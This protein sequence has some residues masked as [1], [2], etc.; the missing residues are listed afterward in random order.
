MA[1]VSA[2]LLFER[3]RQKREAKEQ[4]LS[5]RKHWREIARP[6]QI[7]PEGRWR[8]WVRM[9]GRGEGKTRSGAETTLEKVR[10]GYK[11]ICILA[12]T[13]ADGRDVCVE[14]ESG[15]L[16][17]ALPGEIKAWNRSM[18][19]IYFSTGAKAKIFAAV[20]PER[21]R[22]PQHDWIWADEA[23]TPQYTENVLDMALF[24]LR[25]GQE[26]Q[27][28]VT[29]TPRNT[30]VIRRLKAMEG[31]VITAGRTRDN[32]QNLAPGIVDELERRYAG[33]R[34]GQQELDGILLEDV[35]GAL[36]TS[37]LIDPHRALKLPSNIVSI[38]VGV[39]PSV[40]DPERKKNPNKE[41]DACGIVVCAVS[42]DHQGWVINDLSGVMHPAQ[43][44]KVAAGAYNHYR[45]GVIAAEGNQGGELVKMA[46][47]AVSPNIN[48]Q[49][50]HAS[51]G[52]RARAEPL[53]AL[54]E[55]GRIHHVAQDKQGDPDWAHLRDL[56]DE[57]LTW[58]PLISESPNRV[59]AL[60]WCFD[61]LGLIS[62][63]GFRETRRITQAHAHKQDHARAAH[64]KPWFSQEDEEDE[65]E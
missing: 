17:C 8:I 20:E 52:K 39:D 19:E 9:C 57:M 60:V 64:A 25:L 24:G 37:D 34:I 12:P 16:A 26:P 15:I 61:A 10:A 59:D 29:T 13:F 22:G 21:L 1:A 46:I 55:Q 38:A 56:E 23:G 7:P 30:A 58:E 65:D 27:M 31:V 49:I 11:H 45:A 5:G 32:F 35:E 48:V 4:H 44:S 43:W 41:M 54:Y 2:D 40:A 53:A 28:M 63:G 50:V 14:G 51:I 42:D 36:W 47:H 18:G 6:N 33:T 3:T 62:Q